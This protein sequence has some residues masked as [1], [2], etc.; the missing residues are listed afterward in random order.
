VP[1]YNLEP[2]SLLDVREWKRRVSA[3]IEK[4]GYEEFGKQFRKKHR[5]LI[6]RIEQARQARLSKTGL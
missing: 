1:D 2:Q 3:E 4:I 6:E 5:N